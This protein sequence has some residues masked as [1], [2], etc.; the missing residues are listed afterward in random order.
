MSLTHM[1]AH[2]P[3]IFHAPN[4]HDR[5]LPFMPLTHMTA[6]FPGI[7]HVPNTHDRSLP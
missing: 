3:G 6:Y 4:T 1:T 7:F 2:F 5:S